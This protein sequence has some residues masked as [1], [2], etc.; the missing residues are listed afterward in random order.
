[1]FK[2]LLKMFMPSDKK[3][4]QYAADAIAKAVNR[5]DKEA[6]IAKY[7]TMANK[8][9]EIQSFVVELLVDGKIDETEKNE[10]TE[11]LMPLFAK[12]RELI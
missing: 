2:Y 7:A 10:I 6:L 3:L 5:S 4:A 8:A 11:K 9:T 1:M 12:L